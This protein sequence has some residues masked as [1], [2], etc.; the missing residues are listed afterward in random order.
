[1]MNGYQDI[2]DEYVNRAQADFAR[3]KYGSTFFN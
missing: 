2:T 3:V 1:M